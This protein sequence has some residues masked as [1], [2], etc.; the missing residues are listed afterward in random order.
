[1]P[2]DDYTL[3]SDYLRNIET[4]T[5]L[6]WLI[7]QESK[8]ENAISAVA[9]RRDSV[10]RP[11]AEEPFELQQRFEAL[12][13]HWSTLAQRDDRPQPWQGA[14]DT[15]LIP[16]LLK[17]QPFDT[18]GA[19]DQ[20]VL[21]ERQQQDNLIPIKMMPAQQVSSGIQFKY[22]LATRSYKV[23]YL[24]AHPPRPMGYAPVAKQPF[25]LRSTW[26]KIFTDGIVEAGRSI[27]YSQLA[28][29]DEWRP[30]YG[31]LFLQRVPYTWV[32]PGNEQGIFGGVTEEISDMWMADMDERRARQVEREEKV[33]AWQDEVRPEREAKQ[34]EEF[35]RMERERKKQL[36]EKQDL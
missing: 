36:L 32:Q 21:D 26:D 7:L 18:N 2:T 35:E 9:Q 17:A 14:F 23:S 33:K 27:A 25:A 19:V 12:N 28:G 20:A 8:L 24:R 13:L 22:Y 29:N 34:K 11:R 1:L 15:V 16:P 6:T 5:D 30:I 10:I 3:L 4:R 31:S